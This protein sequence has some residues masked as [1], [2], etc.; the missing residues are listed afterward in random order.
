[1]IDLL[2][3]LPSYPCP[4]TGAA[5]TDF[6]DKLPGIRSELAHEILKSRE[7][8]NHGAL[9]FLSTKDGF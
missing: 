6:T 1:M 4:F 8:L 3:N 2:Q 9:G 7:A 5:V